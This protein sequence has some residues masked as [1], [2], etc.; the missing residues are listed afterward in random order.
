MAIR[1]SQRD[2]WQV[3]ENTFGWRWYQWWIKHGGGIRPGYMENRCHYLR[4]ILL[5][6]PFMWFFIGR[7][8]SWF[9]PWMAVPIIIAIAAYTL[10]F[11]LWTSTALAWTI[12]FIAFTVT[13]VAAYF[14]ISYVSRWID[15]WWAQQQWVARER[16]RQQER[17]KLRTQIEQDRL[18]REAEDLDNGTVQE[19]PQRIGILGLLFTAYNGFHSKTCPLIE[20]PPETARYAIKH[21]QRPERGNYERMTRRL[22]RHDSFMFSHIAIAVDIRL[23]GQLPTGQ[24]FRLKAYSDICSLEVVFGDGQRWYGGLGGWRY[25]EASKLTAGEAEAC[26]RELVA[27]FYASQAANT[28][29]Q[30]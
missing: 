13:L 12:G 11:V 30:S 29:T 3:D 2:T 19:E 28:T 1:S 20:L 24:S 14:A 16:R 21:K 23:D 7:I 8:Y 5:H 25:P 27:Q 4:V 26:L 22:S 9:R 6:V 15:P 18:A 10:A 17:D